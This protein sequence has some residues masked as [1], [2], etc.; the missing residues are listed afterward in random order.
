MHKLHTPF[1]IKTLEDVGTFSG[2]ASVYNVRDAQEEVVAPGAFD[3]CL[4]ASSVVWPKLLWQHDPKE[5]IGQ[6]TALQDD[7]HG[8]FVKGQLFLD[9]QRGKEAHVLMKAG[10]VDGLSIGYIPVKTKETPGGKILESVM[11][12]EISLV[13]FPSNPKARVQAVKQ[14][15]PQWDPMEITLIHIQQDLENLKAL[16]MS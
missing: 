15:N 1:F 16:L 3:S 4:Q 13:T 10:V 11:L 9:L 8:L 5:P 6:W 2:Y 7:G 12:H 14:W